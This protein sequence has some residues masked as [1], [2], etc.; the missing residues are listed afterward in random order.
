MKQ[1]TNQKKGAEAEPIKR[2]LVEE[3]ANKKETQSKKIAEDEKDN[4]RKSINRTYRIYG[5]PSTVLRILEWRKGET[6]VL[7][8][9]MVRTP[10]SLNV[11]LRGVGSGSCTTRG[12]ANCLGTC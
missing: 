1:P 6:G 5:R 2:C 8:L 12:I 4:R 9:S 3:P 7:G 11:T 10:E